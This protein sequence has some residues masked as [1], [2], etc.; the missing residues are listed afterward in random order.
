MWKKVHILSAAQAFVISSSAAA[1]LAVPFALS[2][3]SPNETASLHDFFLAR[4]ICSVLG[5]ELNLFRAIAFFSPLLSLGS[6]RSYAEHRCL[7]YF[8]VRLSAFSAR[9]LLARRSMG[10]GSR[11]QWVLPFN[12]LLNSNRP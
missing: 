9:G 1:I 4:S 6:A 7:P 10:G 3:A 2:V 8:L 12:L 5:V 11:I